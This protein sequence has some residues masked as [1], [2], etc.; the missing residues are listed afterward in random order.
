MEAYKSKNELKIFSRRCRENHKTIGFVPTMGALHNGHIS[1]I[2]AAKRD[3]DLVVV[4]IFVNPMQFN[5]SSDF[6]KYPRMLDEDLKMLEE[7]GV[8]AVFIPTTEEMYPTNETES[9]DFGILDRI[10]E[11]KL[12]PGHFLGVARIVKRLFLAVNPDAAY[13]GEKDFQQLAIIKELTAHE[14]FNIRIVGCPIIREPDGLA[15]SSRNL[16]LG[17]IYRKAATLIYR[18]L[19][20][21]REK[22][23]ILSPDDCEKW[24][25]MELSKEANLRLEYFEIVDY[26]TMLPVEKPIVGRKY[27]GCTAVYAG[28]VRLIDN[29]V[30][31]I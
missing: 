19:A 24:F 14:N 23:H 29:M 13:F 31:S 1:L 8:N 20:A 10:M 16:R 27:I 6:Q 18:T 21:T 3:N 2:D 12:R 25:R 30:F 28:E 11:A 9:F 4:S 17:P 5:D 26:E 22:F 7:H 15:M